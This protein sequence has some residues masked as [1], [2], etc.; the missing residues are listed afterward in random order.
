MF[1]EHSIQEQQIPG[2]LKY[3]KDIFFPAYKINLKEYKSF[4]LCSQ[5]KTE[6]N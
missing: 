1:L 6:L 2:I 5:I 3:T 4:K